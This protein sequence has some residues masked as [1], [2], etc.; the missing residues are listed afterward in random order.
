MYGKGNNP[1]DWDWAMLVPAFVHP[2]R[3]QI[4]EAM[5]WIGQPM[6]AAELERIFYGS[7]GL[8][9]I[10]YHLKTLANAS[11]LKCVRTRTVRGATEH[12]FWLTGVKRR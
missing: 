12:F 11:I 9:S 1:S 6:S 4:I 10:S 8:G 2:T 3:I 5:L 7:P